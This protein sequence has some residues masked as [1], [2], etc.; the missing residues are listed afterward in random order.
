[1]RAV[2]PAARPRA[3]F[4]N[5]KRFLCFESYAACVRLKNERM[6]EYCSRKRSR[7]ITRI[8]VYDIQIQRQCR[9]L[10]T[11]SLAHKFMRLRSFVVSHAFVH[12]LVR[13]FVRCVVVLASGR[14]AGERPFRGQFLVKS[15]QACNASNVL[16]VGECSF[17]CFE[18]ATCRVSMR[19]PACQ[20]RH[21]VCSVR[22]LAK[23]RVKWR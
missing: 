16:V 7:Y 21:W 5:N 4:F 17:S 3:F 22:V 19:T 15:G 1:M 11:K 6:H 18:P 20:K 23:A 14:S 12:A 2:L 8:N 13:A 10:I 9:Q